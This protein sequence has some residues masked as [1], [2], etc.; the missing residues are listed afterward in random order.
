MLGGLSLPL[1]PPSFTPFPRSQVLGSRRMERTES[2]PLGAASS[3]PNPRPQS[4]EAELQQETP[5]SR[6]RG[7]VQVL[8]HPPAS[9]APP[10]HWRIWPRL[11]PLP[12]TGPRRLPGRSGRW[13]PMLCA[14]SSGSPS[15]AMS[16][17]PQRSKLHFK[18]TFLKGAYQLN[19]EL[20]KEERNERNN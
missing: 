1:S 4:R 3:L 14:A 5:R 10:R 18:V 12:G 2:L 6:A 19:Q 13:L 17:Y 8:H 15:P 16:V 20:G 7:P 11:L 9:P